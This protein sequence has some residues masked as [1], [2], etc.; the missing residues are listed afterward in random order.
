[1]GKTTQEERAETESMNSWVCVE[2]QGKKKKYQGWRKEGKNIFF[3]NRWRDKQSAEEEK[4]LRE[5]W[6]SKKEGR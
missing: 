5:G 2:G 3:K 4:V 1:M 6:E